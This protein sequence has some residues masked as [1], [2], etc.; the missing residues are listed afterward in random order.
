MRGRGLKQSQTKQRANI[1]VFLALPAVS[2]WADYS[3]LDKKVT[4]QV[5]Q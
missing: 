5:W 1:M 4:V 3:Y 2:D